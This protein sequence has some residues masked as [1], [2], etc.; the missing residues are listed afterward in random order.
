ME[1]S[2]Q[3][4]YVAALHC[5]ERSWVGQRGILHMEAEIKAQLFCQEFNSCP[6][7]KFIHFTVHKDLSFSIIFHKIINISAMPIPFFQFHYEYLFIISITLL[8]SS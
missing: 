2:G 3:L 6:V 1:L 4:Y 8:L 7:A 5:R